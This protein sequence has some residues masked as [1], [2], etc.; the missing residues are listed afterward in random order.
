VFVMLKSVTDGGGHGS[1]LVSLV[2]AV[3]Y[4]GIS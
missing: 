3:Q 4:G 1:S 2:I